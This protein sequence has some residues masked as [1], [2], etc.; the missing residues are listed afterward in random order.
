MMHPNF[1]HWHNRVELKP[2]TTV[3][4]Q[5][6]WDAAAKFSEKLSGN[7]ACSLLR[8]ALFGTA[9]PEFAKRFSAE[10]VVLEPTFL[11]EG[12]AELLRV[13]ATAALYSQMRKE[14]NEA[15]AVA[16]GL[17][18][19]AFQSDRIDP[20]CKELAQR[21]AEYLAS[22]AERVRPT[23]AVEGSYQ[24][25]KTATEAEGWA[26]EGGATVLVGKAI[27]ELGET[28]G[29]IAEENQFLWW[30]LGRRSSL[31]NM[32]RE[33]LS[34][35]EYAL[36]AGAEAAE[37][38]ALLP[39][40]ASMESLIDEVLSQCA[41]ATNSPVPLV[42]FVEAANLASLRAATPEVD[43]GELCPLL[44]LVEVRRAGA[45]ADSAS[46]KKLS[47]P[48]KLKV[49]P[50]EVANQYFRELMFLRALEQLD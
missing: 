23:P 22:E 15:D 45:K 31:L 39:P 14:S 17:F 3:L 28:M 9:A 36:L 48:A 12:N 26:D 34:Q 8:L 38:V 29:R 44:G 11:P 4:L 30:L 46:L 32:R 27:L 33:K 18:S 40:P 7:D 16:L 37:R 35:K 20:I 41:K 24:A 49:S 1:Y 19:V 50:F 13:M 25:L 21:A 5:A 42:D 10:L 2:D 47:I 6:R 43:V